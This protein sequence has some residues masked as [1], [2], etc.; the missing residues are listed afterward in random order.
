MRLLVFF[1]S[2]A[3]MTGLSAEAETVI[4]E[5]VH[6]VP[7]DSPRVLRDRRVIVRD[8][9]IL[10]IEDSGNT[11]S[12]APGRNKTIDGQGAYLMPGLVDMHVHLSTKFPNESEFALYL[13]NGVTTVRD[14]STRDPNLLKV[15]KEIEAG[16]RLGPNL[17]LASPFSGGFA[18][19]PSDIWDEAKTLAALRSYVQN[20]Y[21]AFKVGDNFTLDVYGA[22]SQAAKELGF[23]LVGHVPLR[24]RASQAIEAGQQTIE[25]FYG[26][27][28]EGE[29]D[30][31]P[32]KDDPRLIAQYYLR[33]A[34][35]DAAKVDRI[36][37]LAASARTRHTATSFIVWKYSYGEAYR[38]VL[39]SPQMRYVPRDKLEVDRKFIEDWISL[40]KKEG[41]EVSI[42]KAFT[43]YLRKLRRASRKNVPLLI[44]TDSPHVLPGFSYHDELLLHRRA[45]LTPY[46]ILKSATIGAHASL[47]YPI[48]RTR[49]KFGLIKPGYRADLVLVKTNPLV[50]MSGLRRPEGVMVR[51][52]WLS[53]AK[54]NNMLK[55]VEEA[56]QSPRLNES[57]SHFIPSCEH[58]SF[59]SDVLR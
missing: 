36:L 42:K 4:F 51:G 47:T 45:G 43:N 32:L 17:L 54:L 24:V 22:L 21:D 49:E 1:I 7:M 27:N 16:T 34:Y 56:A 9:R 50:D 58:D 48:L 46:Q 38:K 35:M 33:G 6:V 10:R 31:S 14:M 57:S 15:R 25:H 8:G 52:R 29:S 20:G 44:G 23:P 18:G 28:Q 12:Q 2:I 26:Y 11:D 3:M 40:V 30:D 37:D 59:T 13:A 41:G 5:H 19:T 53:R 39:R 55:K